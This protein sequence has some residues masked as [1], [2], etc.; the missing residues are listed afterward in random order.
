M[1]LLITA[2]K[3]PGKLTGTY[4]FS[5]DH[6]DAKGQTDGYLGKMVSNFTGSE[7]NL[8]DDRANKKTLKSS[9]QLLS[10]IY[11]LHQYF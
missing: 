10:V 6:K 3:V 5:I 4:M 2:K 1:R 11:V 7:Y 8:Y 9:E